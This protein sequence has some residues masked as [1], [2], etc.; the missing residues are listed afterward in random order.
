MDWKPLTAEEEKTLKYASRTGKDSPYTALLAAVEKGPVK[1]SVPADSS[2]QSLK[3]ALSRQ[4]KRS[5]K[6]IVISTLADKSAVVLT[7]ERSEEA[8]K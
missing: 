5:G 3:W 8:K 6:R 4:I 1:V 7:L 2:L